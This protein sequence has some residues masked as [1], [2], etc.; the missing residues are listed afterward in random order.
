MCHYES[1]DIEFS[2]H[3]YLESYSL[4]PKLQDIL[5]ILESQSILS[6]TKIIEKITKNYNI[7]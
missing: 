3:V 7:K 1:L 4:H 5:R 2:E 6:L